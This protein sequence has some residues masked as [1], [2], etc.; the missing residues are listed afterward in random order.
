MFDWYNFSWN[1]VVKELNSDICKGLSSNEVNSNREKYG[2]NTTLNIKLK[3]SI[4]LFIRE[5]FKLYSLIGFAISFLL[6]YNKEVFSGSLIFA[7][8]NFCVILFFLKNY[9]SEK[10]L[11][12]LDKITPNEALVIRNGK[13]IKINAEEIVIGDIVY[14]ERG[15]IVPADLRLIECDDLKIKESA[16]T[17]DNTVVEKYSTKIEDKEITLSEMKNIAFKSSF[18]I[19]GSAKG[20]VIAVG[21]NTE[22]GKTIQD[23]IKEK[24]DINIFEKNISGIINI[25]AVVFLIVSSLILFYGIY[26]KNL[27]FSLKIIPLIYLVLVPVHMIFAVFVV[28]FILK[29]NMRA[30]GI[31]FKGLSSIQ[32]LSS[33]NIIFIDKIGTLT[34]EE[35]YVDKIFT[36]SKIL[37]ENSNEEE[38]KDNIYRILSIGL[39]CNDVRRNMD[40]DIVK[41][42]FIEI[43]LVK[44]GIK[45]SLDKRLLDKEMERIFSIPYDRDKRIKTSLNMVEDKYRANIR[46]S[47]D[48]LLER[49]T[50]I[51]KNGV[52]VEITDKDI[53]E[54]RNAD[55]MMSKEYLYV[56]GFAYRNFNYEPS[57]NE[58][59]ESNLVFVGLVGFENP[60]KENSRSYID[61]CRSLAVKPTVITEDN[62][63]T[64]ESFGKKIG[65][66]NKNDIVL[67]EVEIDHM[68]E[69]EIEKYIERV[70]IFSKISSKTKCKISSMFQKLG[71]NLAV[72]GNRFT[73]SPSLRTAHIGIASGPR[74]TNITKKLADIYIKD[75]DILNLLSL[76]EES[77][78]LMKVL[79]DESIFILVM[80]IVQLISILIPTILGYNIPIT[81][82]RILFINF[83][84][85]ILSY[86]LIFSQ[87]KNIKIK[88]YE[89]VVID[90][91]IL[92]NFTNGISL[93]GIGMG[94]I[95]I[96]AF[97]YGNKTSY[98]LGE[99]NLFISLNIS[100]IIFS[101][102]FSDIK[103]II[104]NKVSFFVLTILIFVMIGITVFGDKSLILNNYNNLKFIIIIV[105]AQ[106]IVTIF[107]KKLEE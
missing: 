101:C 83:V 24:Q 103:N 69:E 44:Y 10:N 94:I 53:N 39:L 33:T 85:L 55:L 4:F 97:Y 7:M 25:L 57:I 41:G 86:I 56:E 14:L 82:S 107:M 102:Y 65:L 30:K 84:T 95:S 18:V 13:S 32:R 9:S 2:E 31:Y 43:S 59:I 46:G 98:Y 1:E 58:N 17:G 47:I 67:S 77:R 63:I 6:I 21:E 91:S 61:Y 79:K 35:M 38:N 73:D 68:E 89:G 62:K 60:I 80:S 29:N 88:N 40:G 99:F 27:N 37:E 104:K 87:H 20:I 3:S 100:C 54:I 49:C 51:M 22:I 74:C 66:L 5:I 16:V 11:K 92:E 96:I 42:D 26:N 12:E 93:Y 28:G 64:A 36:N 15:D 45:N 71:Y 90:K 78:K 76:I 23:F 48:R 75:N 19:D 50:H 52:E 8:I 34:E 70:G 72:T 106:I 105:V 81:S